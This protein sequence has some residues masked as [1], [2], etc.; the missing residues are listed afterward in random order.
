M[1]SPSTTAPEAVPAASPSEP[2][3]APALT[4]GVQQTVVDQAPPNGVATNEGQEGSSHHPVNSTDHPNDT[5]SNVGGSA[6]NSG[7][8]EEANP[9]IKEEVK[10]QQG[11]GWEKLDWQRGGSPAPSTGSGT[12]SGMIRSGPMNLAKLDR[13]DRLRIKTQRNPWDTDSWTALLGEAQLRGDPNIVRSIFEGIVGQ[14]P[15]TPRFWIAYLEYEQKQRDFGR[16]EALFRR[17]LL[18]V[19]SVDLWRFY[20]NY[21]RRTHS[22]PNVPPEK[23]QEA[24]Q[25][26]LKA[27]EY[28]LQHVGMD[29]DS[30]YIWSDYLFFIKSGETSSTYE[31]QQKMD[32]LRRVYQRAVW[33]PLIN[34][35]LLWK[36]YDAFEN[37]LNKLTAKKFLSE[38]SA[39]YMTA[40][41]ALRELK[42][43]LDPIDKVQKTYS[44]KPPTWDQKD[45]NLLAAWKAY[46][47]WER[48]NPLHLDDKATLV[49]RITYAYKSALLM[50]RFY[51]EL[52]YD[53]ASYLQEV[54][55][56]D[57]AAV[58]LKKGIETLPT[59]LLLNFTLAEL[60]ESRKRPYA[61]I[62]KLF[63]NLIAQSE[64]KMEEINAK[65]DGERER[66]MATL[67]DPELNQKA[68]DWDGERR[69]RE[70]E[71]LRE[72]EKEI[73]VKV[74]E[75]RAQELYDNKKSLALVWIV[76]MR[77]SRRSQNIKAARQ[78][79]SRAR[80]SPHCTYHVYVASAL[81]EY[82][83]NKDSGL[84]GRIFEV[85]LK[86]FNLSEDPHVSQFVMQYLDFLIGLND[87]N[88]TR[89][90]FERALAAL[91][92]ENARE[93]WGKFLDYENQYGE[94]A[95]VSR[96]EKRRAEAYPNGTPRELRIV[97]DRW[98]YLDISV[99]GDVELG[100]PLLDAEGSAFQPK[101]GEPT[102]A[103][104]L[105]GRG[106][107]RTNNRG[108]QDGQIEAV[109]PERYPRPDISKYAAY[110]PEPVTR[111]PVVA[112]PPA[113]RA[114]QSPRVPP[115]AGQAPPPLAQGAVGA[116]QPTGPLIPEPIARFMNMLPPAPQYNGPMIP[117]D[118][119]VDFLSRAPIP[120]PPVPVT[121]VP[122]PGGSRLLSAMAGGG[123]QVRSP[124][125][126]GRSHERDRDRDRS[127]EGS[128]DR[129]R[130]RDGGRR[131]RDWDR[132]DRKGRGSRY[133]GRGAQMKR[134]GQ[135]SD[136]DDYGSPQPSGY[137]KRQNIG[138]M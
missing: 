82:Y 22:G 110:K 36:D 41:T 84:A 106:A 23:R 4:E 131:D 79:F 44:A 98:R 128:Y 54:G 60:E 105:G 75:K 18:S 77:V 72:K 51:P 25:T 59:S 49:G 121:M 7:I 66:L 27:F 24:R 90:L 120:L 40:R 137:R 15:S 134:K 103:S 38:K 129:D 122:I 87:D 57:E 83:C 78:V 96:I 12:G 93:I 94:L 95:N 14:F 108:N 101:E 68:D 97:A 3:P 89:A 74:E 88:N 135:Y 132:D 37:N 91:P 117:V 42:N 33:I 86:A 133:G 127:R 92:P 63:D 58:F 116:A 28:V 50:L 85:G 123:S 6:A 115:A 13:M 17:C 29:K 55:K 65:Y 34:I 35:E 16:M 138:D 118:E 64:A 130:G 80:K 126:G 31:E 39:G 67:R 100:L 62:Q 46:I 69:E 10:P 119:L 2:S 112:A 136:D 104:G 5:L 102:S 30:G 53:A 81:M 11:Q 76:Y 56:A 32:H 113:G 99:V 1:A 48:S 20:L 73:Q 107:G 21:I 43:L 26:V 19:V 45:T 8:K 114:E 109:H 61:E 47:A 70:R 124:S 71:K 125:F 111:P 52:W 9:G